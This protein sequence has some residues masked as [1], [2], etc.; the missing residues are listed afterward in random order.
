MNNLGC[1]KDKEK[2]VAELLSTKHNTEK[3]VCS[4]TLFNFQKFFEGLFSFT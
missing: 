4:D 1:F 3:I 2:L